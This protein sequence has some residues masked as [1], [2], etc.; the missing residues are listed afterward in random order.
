MGEDIFENIKA[1][2]IVLPLTVLYDYANS[3]NNTFS[4]KLVFLIEK[5]MEEDKDDDPWRGIVIGGNK[6]QD[7]MKLVTRAYIVAPGLSGYRFYLLKLSYKITIVYPCQI[8]SIIEDTRYECY[9][10]EQVKEKLEK[11]FKSDS[12]QRPVKMLLSQLV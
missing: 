9:D 7:E 6:E 1:E 2:D 12:F 4:E 5:S 11:I 3:F 8:D 10:A